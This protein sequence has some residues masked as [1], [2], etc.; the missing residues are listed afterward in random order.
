MP[1]HSR[2]AT[3]SGSPAVVAEPVPRALR[4][5]VG[6]DLVRHPAGE[7]A[8]VERPRG[9][10]DQ[11]AR[12]E[13]EV[14]LGVGRHPAGRRRAAP[15]R[16][17]A[18]ASTATAAAD[19][20]ARGGAA[21]HIS[22]ARGEQADVDPLERAP[23]APARGRAAVV[24]GPPASAVRPGW[25]RTSRSSGRTSRR[26][27]TAAPSP[28][29]SRTWS[30]S[31]HIER[32]YISQWYGAN[33]VRPSA[34]AGPHRRARPAG[35]AATAPSTPVPAWAQRWSSASRIVP[36]RSVPALKT[37]GPGPVGGEQAHRRR[38]RRRGRTG[39]GW[40][41]RRARSGR[42]RRR[43]SRTG[44]RRCRG[45]RGRGSCAGARSSRRARRRRARRQAHSAASLAWPYASAGRGDRGRQHRVG[46]GH[47]EHRARRR[48][49]DLGRRR[50]RA[51]ASSR[52]CGAVDVDRAQQRRVAGERDL[53]DV[54]VHD[55]DAVDGARARRR[56]RGCRRRR[57]RRRG[58]PAPVTSMSSTP[59]RRRRAATSRSTRSGPK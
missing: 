2:W 42:R 28:S 16:R 20:A 4:P 50:R 57:T 8:A 38:G 55:V 25:R 22:P 18:G 7:L 51:Q 34:G 10:G 14:E 5:Q 27:T 13:V 47:A 6:D 12:V 21:R 35:R 26:S 15:G 37:A 43:S 3:Q 41:R 45:G 17:R 52:T 24:R 56:G 11:P 59:D 36:K 40:C 54:V 19:R 30:M 29:A 39:S 46:L 23:S 58:S 44:C 32:A 31:N 1:I 48:V 33:G 53:G 9:V 49:H